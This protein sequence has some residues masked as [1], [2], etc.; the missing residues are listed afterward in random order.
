MLTREEDIDRLTRIIK[1]Q[2]LDLLKSAKSIKIKY[3]T[4][5]P[6]SDK[7]VCNYYRS[8]KKALDELADSNI[9][10]EVIIIQKIVEIIESGK[11]DIE[12]V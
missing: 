5:S 8:L 11:K 1:E 9:E 3:F 7:N 6:E 12:C 2:L 10:L 4:E